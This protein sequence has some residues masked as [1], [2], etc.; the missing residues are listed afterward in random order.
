MYACSRAA[1][2]IC[3]IH[4]LACIHAAL[5]AHAL[6]CMRVCG[7]TILACICATLHV[8]IQPVRHTSTIACTRLTNLHAYVQSSFSSSSSQHACARLMDG[9]KD[10]SDSAL[11]AHSTISPHAQAMYTNALQQ[12]TQ[13]LCPLNEHLLCSYVAH[14]IHHHARLIRMRRLL[15]TARPRSLGKLL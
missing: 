13:M 10:R 12:F 9:S 2:A 14:R 3:C 8:H 5:H 1:L 6:S 11:L 4:A 7:H 15:P